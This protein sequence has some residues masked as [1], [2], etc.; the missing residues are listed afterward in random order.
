MTGLLVETESESAN[1]LL[2]LLPPYKLRS[3]KPEINTP[4]SAVNPLSS[5]APTFFAVI[6][7]V[8]IIK[9]MPI[10]RTAQLA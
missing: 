10:A 4:A 3:Q 9:A 6:K 7:Y 1:K 2:S 8:T 5:F